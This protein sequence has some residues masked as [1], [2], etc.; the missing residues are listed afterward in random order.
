[1]K[2]RK[3][4]LKR[5]NFLPS[6][7]LWLVF[8]SAW[9]MILFFVPPANPWVVFVFGFLFFLANLFFWSLILAQTKIGFVV[10][11]WLICFL[12]LARLKWLT[13]A[14]GLASFLG[15]VLL[16]KVAFLIKKIRA[17]SPKRA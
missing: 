14:S 16:L 7:I 15:M 13:F 17:L 5:R 2:K 4:D 11:L 6:L 10:S 1:M 3:T 12:I 9:L 8:L